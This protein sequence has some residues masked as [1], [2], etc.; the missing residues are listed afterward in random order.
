M[1]SLQKSGLLIK[2]VSERIENEAKEQTGIFLSIS[3]STLSASLLRNLS[4]R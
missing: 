4:N 3:I 2:D 1:K